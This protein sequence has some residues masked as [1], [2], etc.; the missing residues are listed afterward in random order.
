VAARPSWRR[1]GAAALCLMGLAS[2]AGAAE[3]AGSGEVRLQG[4][5]TSVNDAGP[6]A[7]ANALV[8]GIVPIAGSGLR[9]EAELRGSWHPAATRPWLSSLDADVLLAANRP[10]GGPTD[11][12]SR[13]NEL[14]AASDFGAWQ[15]DAGKKIVSWGVGYGFR[16]N[17]VVQQER[18]RTLLPQ[19]PEGRALDP[20]SSRPPGVSYSV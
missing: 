7:A 19:T 18:R 17:D 4:E 16:P 1:I 5:T 6:L 12:A 14:H 13:I 10:Q 20:F 2:S 8:P 11:N 15:L 9:L 3:V